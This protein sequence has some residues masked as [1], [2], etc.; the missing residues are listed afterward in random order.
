MT[1]TGARLWPADRFEALLAPFG[2]SGAVVLCDEALGDDL[3]I[4]AQIAAL[5]RLGTPVRTVDLRAPLP[6]D[7]P[8]APALA[9]VLRSVAGAAGA[10]RR[11]RAAW[12]KIQA[13]EA[14]G[15]G[16]AWRGAE[17]E[18]ALLWRAER[19]AAA[20]AR[21]GA[22]GP[23]SLIVANNLFGLRVG[24]ALR[25]RR[26]GAMVY[27]AHEIESFR[28]LARTGRVRSAMRCAL[29]RDGLGGAAA[30]VTVGAHI[31]ALLD[32][33]HGGARFTVIHND[34]F[35]DIDPPAR[36]G[37]GSPQLVFFGSAAP[38]RNLEAAAAAVGAGVFA[39][40]TVFAVGEAAKQEAWLDAALHGLPDERIARRVG[41]DYAAELRRWRAASAEPWSWLAIAP[42]TLSYR[43]ALPNKF[44]QSLRA[45][46]PV[47]AL[48][49][50]YVATLARRH[51]LGIV[52]ADTR[53]ET[54][55]AA[56]RGADHGALVGAIERV[57][58]SGAVSD[59]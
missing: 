39:G 10:W 24:V 52:V 42:R 2:A 46:I 7:A 8:A 44:F 29:E 23:R 3:R 26:G 13:T 48:E 5:E 31:A 15:A 9:G 34:H 47:I 21:E 22:G 18:A 33:L 40:L 38:G 14:P 20:L 45:R 12:R 6:A 35:E 49:G 27:D 25:R 37:P 11:R 57:L 36:P 53:P 59:F 16:S 56:L 43:L 17:R 50:G 28:N 4:R 51:G 32:G 54:V 19:R 55:A 41:V 30:A 58:G 1:P